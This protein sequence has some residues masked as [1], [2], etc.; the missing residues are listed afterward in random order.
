M[1]SWSK[2]S[3]EYLTLNL[4]KSKSLLS[5]KSSEASPAILTNMD[6]V[7][8]AEILGV[9]FDDRLEWNSHVNFIVKQS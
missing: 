6:M 2:D 9:I 1:I 5:R 4:R 8:E 7:H 3:Y